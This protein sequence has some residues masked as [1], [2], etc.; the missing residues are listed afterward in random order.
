MEQSKTKAL[1]NILTGLVAVILVALPFHEFLTT[2]LGSNFGHLDVWRAWKE[3]LIVLTLPSILYL[4]HKTP[5]LKKWLVSD[6]LI[7]L[8]AV[9]SLL[10]IGLGVWARLT[11]RVNNSALADGWIIDLRFFAF[12]FVVLVLSYFTNFLRKNWY[13]IIIYPGLVTVFLGLL[14]LVLPLDFLRHFGYG[15]KTIPAYSTVDQNNAYR[16]IQSTLRGA[17]PFGAYLILVI[18]G[19]ALKLKS[20]KLLRAALIVISLVALFFT[21]SRSGYVGVVV[22]LAVLFYISWLKP[23]WRKAFLTCLVAAVLVGGAVVVG[24]RHNL[25]AEDVFFH[26]S[27]SSRSS[28]SSNSERLNA[29]KSSAESVIDH[30]LGEGPGTAGPASEHNDHPPRIA[31]NFY[32]QIG[33]ELGIAGLVLFLSVNVIVAYRLWQKR[34][35]NLSAFLFAT[36]IGIS[37]V[38]MVSHAWADDTLSLLWWG[39]AGIALSPVILKEEKTQIKNSREKSKTALRAR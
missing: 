36:F 31:E 9:F 24:L 14:Q 37:L 20:S 3:A 16:R 5:K 22:S 15:P 11:D 29:L 34:S 8:I 25:T 30:P 19:L 33:Q 17:D 23:Q 10:T 18:T 38:N 7:Q 21:Y 35:D 27:S 26:T 28:I 32:I 13:K 12:L 39:L 4:I 1:V 6:R 2:W